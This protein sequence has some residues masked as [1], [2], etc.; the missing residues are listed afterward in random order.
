MNFLKNNKGAIVFYLIIIVS[1][2]VIINDVKKD[3]LRE[4]NKYVMTYLSK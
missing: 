2:L 1:S 3:N 4:E